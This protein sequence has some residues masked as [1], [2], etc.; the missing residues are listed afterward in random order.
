MP[1]TYESNRVACDYDGRFK[2]VKD[3]H[4]TKLYCRGH[5]DDYVRIFGVRCRVVE[6][7]NLDGS[8]LACQGDW[9]LPAVP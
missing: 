2:V 4:T 1:M 6:P 9:P 7:R 3:H 5:A 8:V